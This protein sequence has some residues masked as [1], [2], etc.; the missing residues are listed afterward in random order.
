MSTPNK[1]GLSVPQEI[2][3][4]PSDPFESKDVATSAAGIAQA[5]VFLEIAEHHDV[6]CHCF[7]C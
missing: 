4:L 1:R 6:S 2:Y 7:Q 3:H 5:K